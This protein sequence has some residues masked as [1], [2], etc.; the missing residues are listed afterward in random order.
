MIISSFEKKKI[1]ADFSLPVPN[2]ATSQSYEVIRKSLSVCLVQF[3]VN[4]VGSWIFD[5][6]FRNSKVHGCPVIFKS[7]DA[8]KITMC[9]VTDN[10]EVGSR[11]QF[12]GEYFPSF[13]LVSFSLSLSLS[14]SV[15]RSDRFLFTGSIFPRCICL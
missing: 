10:V 5:A 15:G 1:S 3:S 2:A 13:A 9:G 11:V 6:K 8:Q 4:E 14:L 12:E 7:Y